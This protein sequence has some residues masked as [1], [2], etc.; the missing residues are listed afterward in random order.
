MTNCNI[1]YQLAI[2]TLVGFY[3]FIYSVNE[4]HQDRSRRETLNGVKEKEKIFCMILTQP[5]NMLNKV[6]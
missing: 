4:T 3:F 5:K 2:I 6:S 1:L